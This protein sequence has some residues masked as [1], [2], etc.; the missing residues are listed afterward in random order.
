[1]SN[2]KLQPEHP[3]VLMK[4]YYLAHRKITA[5]KLAQETGISRKHLSQILNGHA[6]ITAN[7]AVRLADFL[8]TSAEM[9]LNGQMAYDLWHSKKEFEQ[10]KTLRVE[11]H[12]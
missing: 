10:Q 3:G 6:P 2:R 7:T 9:W 12:V 8:E 1:M 11:A 4:N 5:T